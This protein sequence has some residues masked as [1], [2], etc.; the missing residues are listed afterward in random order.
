MSKIS[1]Y[2]ISCVDLTDWLSPTSENKKKLIYSTGTLLTYLY[3]FLFLVV[4][5]ASNKNS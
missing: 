3:Y 1:T 2:F 5:K 4:S